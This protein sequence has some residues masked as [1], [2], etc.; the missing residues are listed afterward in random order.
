MI[1]RR[2]F[3]LALLVACGARPFLPQSVVDNVRVLASKTDTPYA[4]PGENVSVDLLVADGRR[5][6]TRPLVVGWLPLLCVNPAA[7]LY[8]AC[9][10]PQTRVLAATGALPIPVDPD[11]GAPSA[12]TPSLPAGAL[13]LGSLAGTDIT[14]FLV[15]GERFSFAMPDDVVI[16]HARSGTDYGLVFLFN[17]ACAGRVRIA[18]IDPAAGVQQMPLECVDENGQKLGADDYLVGFTRVY[19]YRDRRNGNPSISRILYQGKPVDL[20]AGITVPVC[21][22]S[23]RADCDTV[24]LDVDAPAESREEKTGETLID[25][26]VPR[27]Q[28]YAQYYS[29]SG[30]F[31]QDGRLLYDSASG[32]VPDRAA[33]FIPPAGAG[34]GRIYVVVKD[35]R[36]GTS[37]VDFPVRAE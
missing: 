19:S 25:G 35:D 17:I 36:G 32:L 26:N 20:G 28:V 5:T 21:T 3:F 30:I 12:T 11:A 16:P 9:F 34:T 27:E 8:F 31:T 14:D 15:P 22:E 7:D 10:A 37:W 23:R 13:D 1:P 18:P 2:F 4:L 29:T 24:E 6:K 33:E